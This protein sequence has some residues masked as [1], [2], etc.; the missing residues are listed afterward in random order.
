MSLL[1]PLYMLAL[2]AV[3]LPIALHLI[4]RV[5]RGQISFSSLM[6][7]SP[8]PPRL[9]RRSRLDH[10]ILLLLR[11]LILSLLAV[12]FSRPFFRFAGDLSFAT[13]DGR[14]V[15]LLVDTSASMRRGDLW[16]QAA[17][18]VEE[19]LA[20]LEPADSVGLF[21]FDGRLQ[22]VVS[23]DENPRR[24]RLGEP[25][26]I[27]R[28]LAELRP[29]WGHTDLGAALVSLA[30]TMQVSRDRQNSLGAQQIVLIS[31]LQQGAMLDT[32]Q[33]SEWPPHVLVAIRSVQVTPPGNA[34]LRVLTDETAPDQQDNPRVRVFNAGD[35]E[36]EQFRLGWASD[37]READSDDAVSIYVPAGQS[38]VVRVPRPAHH[39][40]AD[41]IVL[42]GDGCEF[43]NS[44]F[45]T[46]PRKNEWK[47]LYV[48]TDEAHDPNGLHY[49]LRR[50]L[51]K[52]PHG[53]VE[54]ISRPGDGPLGLDE[55]FTPQL[56]VVS[57]P[58]A[59]GPLE[60]LTTYLENGGVAL[61]VPKSEA[62]AVASVRLTGNAE[63]QSETGSA[64]DD[65]VM[66]ADIDFTHPMFAP[67]N[68]PR[69][70]DFTKI[71]FWKHFPFRL[72]EDPAVNL[73]ARFD[74]GDPA[75]WEESLGKGRV[76][77]LASGWHPTDSQLALSSKFVPLMAA[78]MEQA[79]GS[80]ELPAYRVNDTVTLPEFGDESVEGTLTKPDGT[81]V[82]LA[83]GGS[84]FRGADQPGIYA[85]RQAERR[86]AF[87]VN[88]AA[89]ESDTAPLDLERLE[90]AGV[91][92]GDQPA[93]SQE[94]ERQQQL[95]DVELEGR[96]K[97]W[98]WLIAL[99]LGVII[100]ET[101]WAARHS[102]RPGKVGTYD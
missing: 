36:T 41:R 54:V 25:E 4:R 71:H 31:D 14:Q 99:A 46:P 35:S 49:Y 12:A 84:G 66:L 60:W 50:A 23:F 1:A 67:L 76:L 88:L 30:E 65:Y 44:F 20:E 70:S 59:A 5:P 87:S 48:G 64:R 80:F 40:P 82:V 91:T 37:G 8:S 101:A 86:F 79:G 9:T 29:S 83:S 102:R 75:L 17:G 61:M 38:R 26:V 27:R 58:L 18:R 6:F 92:L 3:S 100:A 42:F 56:V 93:P 19:V 74:N 55:Q 77:V 51:V 11:A 98:R 52:T 68:Q 97:F 7:L 72:E 2:F 10:L 62:A 21:T 24:D 94:L 22:S 39:L 34:S 73:L 16:Q 57:E 95:R 15:A 81:D 78:I 89:R 85:V 53:E 69:Y 28:R 43:D 32:L 96:Q 33:A 63:L 45:V 13:V 90:Q 47:V